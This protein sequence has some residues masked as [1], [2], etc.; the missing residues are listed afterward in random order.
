MTIK[1]LKHWINVCDEMG[2]IIVLGQNADR[3]ESIRITLDNVELL[4]DILKLKDE[5]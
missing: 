4:A 5:D 2:I 3:P 1:D